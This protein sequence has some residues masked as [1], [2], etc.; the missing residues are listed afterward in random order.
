M[1]Q[2]KQG[3]PH[4]APLCLANKVYAREATLFS[5]TLQYAVLETEQA[6][7]P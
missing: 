7:K 2:S 5:G 6:V 3:L 1:N 4:L